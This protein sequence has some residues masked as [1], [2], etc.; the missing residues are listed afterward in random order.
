MY[1]TVEFVVDTITE[2]TNL[3]CGSLKLGYKVLSM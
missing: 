3:C 1:D 2:L